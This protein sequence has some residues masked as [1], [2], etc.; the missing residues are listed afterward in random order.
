MSRSNYDEDNR[1]QT[2]KK[3]PTMYRLVC[4]VRS[5]RCR[6]KTEHGGK[7]TREGTKSGVG[8][9]ERMKCGKG[10]KGR[11]ERS[12]DIEV[13]ITDDFSKI[14]TTEPLRLDWVGK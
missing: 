3:T 8:R 14:N 13:L 9:L 10:I 4:Q 6:L 12:I 2:L 7:R 11:D 1:R 5:W